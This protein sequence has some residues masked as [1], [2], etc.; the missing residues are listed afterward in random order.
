MGHPIFFRPLGLITCWLAHQAQVGI[1]AEVGE[2]GKDLADLAVGKTHPA[3]QRSA[4]LLDGGGG[5]QATCTH[6]IGLVDADQRVLA[7]DVLPRYRSPGDNMV[8]APAVVGTIAV[9]GERA[10]K[11][12]NGEERYL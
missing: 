5:N 6:I 11:V 12:R 3:P 4:V 1:A 7:V 2:V 9:S 8:A 10:A